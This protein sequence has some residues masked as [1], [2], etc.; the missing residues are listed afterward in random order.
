MP[1]H[2]VN[3]LADWLDKPSPI[4]RL[5]GLMSSYLLIDLVLLWSHGL[6]AANITVGDVGTAI[7]WAHVPPLFLA[8][9]VLHGP[10]AT[11]VQ[12]FFGTLAVFIKHG[13]WDVWCQLGLIS[14]DSRV[15]G[16]VA[17]FRLRSWAVK[18]NNSVAMAV[19][20]QWSSDRGDWQRTQDRAFC[21]LVA[22]ML[23]YLSDGSVV[24]QLIEWHSTAHSP[25]VHVA[26]I[27]WLVIMG[28]AAYAG[29]GYGLRFCD[30]END[31]TLFL[32][33]SGIPGTEPTKRSVSDVAR[34]LSRPNAADP[35]S[36]DPS[37]RAGVPGCGGLAHERTQGRGKVNG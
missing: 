13:L 3:S 5:F 22:V 14:T 9:L 29:V 7:P 28:L 30:D 33:D 24:R 32:P 8:V 35:M 12:G 15:S 34:E 20:K 17:P 37:G 25:A 26:G 31:H 36:L 19:L 6:S 18:H 27:G 4:S 16:R 1:L 2:Q 21:F 10:V 11:V 23:G